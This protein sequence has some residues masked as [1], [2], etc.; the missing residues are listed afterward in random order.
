MQG[1][2]TMWIWQECEDYDNQIGSKGIDSKGAASGRQCLGNN[3]GRRAIHYAEYI[4][5]LFADF[6][7]ANLYLRYASQNTKNT[8]FDIYLDG[9]LIGNSPSLTLSPTGGW[10]YLERDWRFATLSLGDISA[11]EHVIKIQSKADNNKTNF[12]GFFIGD[13]DFTLPTNFNAF[14]QTQERKRIEATRREGENVQFLHLP[15]IPRQSMENYPEAVDTIK[16]SIPPELEYILQQSAKK[17]N[18]YLLKSYDVGNSIDYEADY[19]WHS[20]KKEK[21]FNLPH[22]GKIGMVNPNTDISYF[23]GFS[24]GGQKLNYE[25]PSETRVHLIDVLVEELEIAEGVKA[26]IAFLPYTS[27]TLLA[28]VF[29]QNQSSIRKEVFLHQYASKQMREKSH[30]RYERTVTTTTGDIRWAGYDNTNHIA[31]A[32]YDEWG[33]GDLDDLRVGKLLYAL[34]S[35]ERPVGQVFSSELSPASARLHPIRFIGMKYR[36]SMASNSKKVALFSISLQRYSEKVVSIPR[37][38]ELYPQLDDETAMIKVAQDA[39][40]AVTSDWNSRII[41]SIQ[42][43]S[44]M[45]EVSIPQKSWISDFYASLELPRAETYSPYKKMEIPFYNFCRVHAQEPYGWWTYGEHAHES[46]SVFT[47]NIV[48]PELSAMHLRGHLRNQ[49]GD[50]G[51]PYGVNQNSKPSEKLDGKAT[52]PFIVWECWNTYL[53]S[54]DGEFLEDAYRTGVK[55]HKFWMKNRSRSGTDLNH[56]LD[57]VETVRDDSDLPTWTATD[58]AENQEALDLNCYLCVQE[59]CLALMAKELGKSDESEDFELSAKKRMNTINSNL[60]HKE[61]ECYYGKD[62]LNDKWILVK[63]ISTFMPLWAGIA[64]NERAKKLVK[65]LDLPS[66]KTEYPVATL[67]TDEPTFVSDGHW[68]GSNWIEMTWL[69]I[70]G[71]KNYGYYEKASELAYTNVKLV[72]DILEKTGHFREYYDTQTGE[73]G[74]GCLYDY[75]WACLPAAFIIQIIFGIEPKSNGLDIMPALPSDWQEI[76]VK[77]L[78]VRGMPISVKIERSYDIDFTEVKVNDEDVDVV[79]NRGALIPWN[80]LTEDV[81][82]EIQ[83][84]MTISEEHGLILES[85]VLKRSR[86]QGGSYNKKH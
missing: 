62:L 77:K 69:V 33:G 56:W 7:G 76:S 75:I 64:P 71:L 46:L 82:I 2:E 45:P 1:G 43:Y 85:P 51:L 11:G 20:L 16:D 44:P 47:N 67:A 35:S 83:Q 29:L 66:F 32:C 12:D 41:E 42:K 55:N 59:K 22:S 86:S 68:Y 19:V 3:W 54:G 17:P 48:V 39:V 24:V 79:E 38:V 61:D 81:S 37:D 63:D 52:A 10:G 14:A 53:W 70:L 13:K 26:Y 25:I 5:N 65:L 15:R 74:S 73:P 60:W 31:I 78:R 34:T 6:E 57:Y 23:F 49:A 8:V 9:K 4:I 50:G 21:E 27:F 84:P 36:I 58:G 30:Q 18:T 80:D 28:V 72:F 40:K